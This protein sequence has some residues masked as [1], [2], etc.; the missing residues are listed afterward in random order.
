LVGTTVG[1]AVGA[2]VGTIISAMSY[3]VDSNKI[4]TQRATNLSSL[5]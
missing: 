4:E 5:Q 3:N 2:T 1:L